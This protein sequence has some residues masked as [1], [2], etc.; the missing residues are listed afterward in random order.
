MESFA[1]A[2]RILRK[3]QLDDRV[4]DQKWQYVN[5]V[6]QKWQYVNYRIES[7]DIDSFRVC[8]LYPYLWWNIM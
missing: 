1:V 8:A 4:V 6:D 2:I 3:V 7:I 5:Y